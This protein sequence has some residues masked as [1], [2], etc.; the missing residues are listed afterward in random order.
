[1]LLVLYKGEEV[2]F[3]MTF[4]ESPKSSDDD[5]TKLMVIETSQKDG[6]YR[7]AATV[8]TPETATSSNLS[9]VGSPERRA[10]RGSAELFNDQ[11]PVKRSIGSLL[12]LK[13]ADYKLDDRVIQWPQISRLSVSEC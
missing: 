2:S 1:M 13:A 5:A 9:S 4:I 7:K 8:D 12:S 3:N 10:K 11:G 6:Q